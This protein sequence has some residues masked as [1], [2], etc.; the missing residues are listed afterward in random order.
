MSLAT[1]VADLIQYIQTGRILDAMTEFYA[2]DAVMQENNSAPTVGL[3]ANL[4]REKQFLAFVKEWKSLSITAT[5]VN[6]ATG[7]AFIQY[8]FVFIGTDGKTYTYDQVSA[9]TWKNNK[10]TLEKFY[11]DTAAK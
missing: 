2:P 9:Q 7:H 4:E 5:A 8:H 11:Y 6:E 1:R 10:I 3:A